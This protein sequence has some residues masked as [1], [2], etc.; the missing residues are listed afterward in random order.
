MN[1]EC[2]L[3]GQ[4]RCFSPVD[5]SGRSS[6]DLPFAWGRIAL[7]I[8]ASGGAAKIGPAFRAPE[9][10]EAAFADEGFEASR[11]AQRGFFLGEGLMAPSLLP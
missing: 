7:E 4:N 8:V 9:I 10:D 2:P 5:G 1:G 11:F 6:P 3:W